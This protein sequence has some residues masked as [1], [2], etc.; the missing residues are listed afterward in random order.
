MNT[1]LN[2]EQLEAVWM[3]LADGI[4]AAG[5]PNEVK[6]LAKL[7]LLLVTP[8]RL[9]ELPQLIAVAREDL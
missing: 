2:V 1:S 3:A 5:E 7:A 4:T 6:F 9:A 8:D